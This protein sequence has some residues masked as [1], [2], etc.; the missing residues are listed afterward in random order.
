VR[1]DKTP[2]PGPYVELV[3]EVLSRILQ[4]DQLPLDGDFL[5]LGGHSLLAVNASLELVR[6]T[7]LSLDADVLFTHRSVG[8]LADHLAHV[9]LSRRESPVTP[10]EERLLYLSRLH[11][12]SAQYHVPVRYRFRGEIHKHL[13]RSALEEIIRRHDALRTCFTADGRRVVLSEARLAWSVLDLTGED[14]AA[15]GPAA[16]AHIDAEARRPLDV[17]AAPLLRACLVLEPGERTTLLLTLH[18]LIADQHSLDLLDLELQE[19]YG[20]EVGHRQP[21]P[22][23]PRRGLAGHPDRQASVDHWEQQISGLGGRMALPADQERPDLVGPGGDV[24]ET[25]LDAHLVEQLD[26]LAVR[27]SATEFVVLLAA[28]GAFLGRVTAT[29]QTPMASEVVISVPLSGRTDDDET[30]VGMFVNALP[31]RLHFQPGTTFRELIGTTRGL[32]GQALLHQHVPLQDLVVSASAGH[33]LTQVGISYVD[34]RQWFWAPDGAEA[35]RD[36][37]STGTAKY[38]L[39]W[40]L[41]RDKASARSRLEFSTAIFSRRR[42]EELHADL[43]ATLVDLAG[44]PDEAIATV[45]TKDD[46]LQEAGRGSGWRQPVAEPVHRQVEQW[47]RRTPAK[48]AIRDGELSLTYGELERASGRLAG[49]LTALGARPGERVAVVAGR[50]AATVAAFLAVLR[51]GA[52]YLPI[53]TAQPV[54]RSGRLMA[55]SGVRYAICEPGMEAHV[56][57]SVAVVPLTLDASAEAGA[58]EARVQ[59]LPERQLAY[60]IYTSGSTGTPKGVLAPHEG[61]ARLVPRSN[62]L[63]VNPDDVVAHLSN[64]AFDAATFE[65]WGALSAGA[66]LVVVPRTV[67]LSPD[68]L[69]RLLRETGVSI[70]FTTNALLNVLVAQAPDIFARVRALLLGGD[71]YSIETLRRMMAAGGPE[72]LIHVYGPTENTTYSTAYEVSPADL[73]AGLLPIGSAIAG[74]YLR[75]LDERF[76]PVGAGQSGELYVGGQGLADGYVGD[77]GRTSGAFVADPFG[78][79]SGQRLYRTGDMVRQLAGGEVVFLGRTDDQVKIRG[80]RVE[81]GEVEQAIA[82]CP[83]VLDGAVVPVTTAEGTELVV[84]T[85]GEA[86]TEAVRSHFTSKLPAYMVPAHHRTVEKLPLNPSGKVDRAALQAMVLPGLGPVAGT[87]GSGSATGEPS[88]VDHALEQI[89]KDLLGVPAVSGESDFFG[90]G[91]SSI[92]AMY[93]VAAIE[94]DLGAALPITAVFRHP[95]FASLAAEITK[96]AGR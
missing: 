47:A 35:E 67:A 36:V 48:T 81:L 5:E 4:R 49:Q 61:V 90:L 52:A 7:G 82:G 74:T 80:F 50:G 73:E 77:P 42:A 11:P 20:A 69:R 25:F 88:S 3:S 40:T 12:L 76:S 59:P 23:F 87:A 13:L 84:I 79:G 63:E 31:I 96:S 86:S 68:S 29:G 14:P 38:E 17:T 27:S 54:D 57:G 53:D 46:S 62:Y 94:R 26:Q 56:P 95:T 32:L 28:Y 9:S 18:H 51:A 37:L 30:T 34:D 83:D 16:A 65:I 92:K 91:G 41:T 93:L 45:L 72:R 71:Q 70:I 55:D 85:V 44:R 22:Q 66:T 60:V 15:A 8:D 39:L 1:P 24:V 33:P 89:W 2:A 21:L 64:T 75:V 58:F 19:L 6:R 43:E 10:A 78:D